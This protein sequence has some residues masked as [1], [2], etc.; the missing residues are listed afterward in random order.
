MSRSIADILS[1]LTKPSGVQVPI[2]DNILNNPDVPNSIG[3]SSTNRKIIRDQYYNDMSLKHLKE[4]KN[5]TGYSISDNGRLRYT[6]PREDSFLLE[7][8]IDPNQIR[9][10]TDPAHSLPNTFAQGSLYDKYQLPANAYIATDNKSLLEQSRGS[11]DNYKNRYSLPNNDNNDKGEKVEIDNIWKKVKGLPTGQ[12]P[13]GDTDTPL[14]KSTSK[15]P[16]K[17]M[18]PDKHKKYFF[19]PSDQYV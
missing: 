11:F 7:G 16:N 15:I 6:D 2:S 1:I 14:D 8:S 4:P 18:Y 13:D 5:G 10:Q 19:D 9:R 3:G 17:V 12:K